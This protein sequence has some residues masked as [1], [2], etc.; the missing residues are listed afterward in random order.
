ML[1]TLLRASTHVAI[2]SVG[3]MGAPPRKPAA[4]RTIQTRPR[5]RGH[6]LDQRKSTVSSAVNPE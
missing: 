3:L 6:H 5:R 1:T 2:L 4:I